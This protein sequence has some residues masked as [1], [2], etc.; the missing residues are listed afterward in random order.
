MPKKNAVFTLEREFSEEEMA[1]LRMG[2]IPKEMEDK[3]FLYMEDNVLYAHRSWTGICVYIIEFKPDNKHKVTVN[4]N[5]QQVDFKSTKEAAASGI[6]R[7][8][9][10]AA[11][12]TRFRPMTSSATAR[13]SRW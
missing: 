8:A 10:P 7:S 3:W 5:R 12:T 1:V 2:N 11:G 9:P 4:R 13:S 6:S